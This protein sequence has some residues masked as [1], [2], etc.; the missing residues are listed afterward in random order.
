[1]FN[2]Y[3]YRFDKYCR[4]FLFALLSDPKR[5]SPALFFSLKNL[6]NPVT[7]FLCS[8][9]LLGKLGFAEFKLGLTRKKNEYLDTLPFIKNASVV[10]FV[11]RRMCLY[12]SLEISVYFFVCSHVH[13]NQFFSVHFSSKHSYSLVH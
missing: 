7:F 4:E 10:S 12:H 8:F 13:A 6:S 11:Y 5:Q 3:S 2:I 9:F 1:M